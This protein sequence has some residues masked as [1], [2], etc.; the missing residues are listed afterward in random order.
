MIMGSY[1]YPRSGIFKLDYE[2]ILIFRKHGSQPRVRK[3]TKEKSRLTQEEWNQY[4]A[5]HWKLFMKLD[6]KRYDEEKNLLCYLYLQ[7]KTFL[8]AHL[9]KNGLADV[10]TSLDYKHK[11]RLLGYKRQYRGGKR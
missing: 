5:G 11:S 10:D 3:E 2:F 8:N 6:I 9:T 1:P 7:N 4:F